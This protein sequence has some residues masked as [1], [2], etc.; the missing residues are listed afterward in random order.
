MDRVFENSCPIGNTGSKVSS[1]SI[2]FGTTADCYCISDRRFGIV[3][4]EVA[5]VECCIST[6]NA[7][8]RI[9]LSVVVCPGR[10]RS[11]QE[12]VISNHNNRQGRNDKGLYQPIETEVLC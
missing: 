9:Q 10:Y 3:V 12:V 6:P 4:D 11:R 8:S 2:V 1:G 7:H 5:I